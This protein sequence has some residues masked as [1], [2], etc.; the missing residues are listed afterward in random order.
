LGRFW[1]GFILG[2]TTFRILTALVESSDDAMMRRLRLE[3]FHVSGERV[4]EVDLRAKATMV[5]QEASA[6]PRIKLV[7]AARSDVS[8]NA[9]AFT[10]RRRTSLTFLI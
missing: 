6:P 2:R 4:I 5:V 3:D 7:K 10:R 8:T 9:E 1:G